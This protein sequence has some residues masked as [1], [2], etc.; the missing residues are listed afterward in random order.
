MLTTCSGPWSKLYHIAAEPFD[1]ALGM[2]K[3]ALY[4]EK[5]AS[6]FARDG[7]ALHAGEWHSASW[8]PGNVMSGV[9][10]AHGSICAMYS[11]NAA[12]YPKLSL[13]CRNASS[14]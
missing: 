4:A 10:L 3:R 5:L 14:A 2:R 13:S 12:S 7:D 8:L 9:T 1:S 11:S 6:A